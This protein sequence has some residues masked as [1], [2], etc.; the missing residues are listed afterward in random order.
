MNPYAI[1]CTNYIDGCICT[2]I[3][4]A[5]ETKCAALHKMAVQIFRGEVVGLGVFRVA[6]EAV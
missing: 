3:L 4:T 1:R 6:T 5:A 2:A